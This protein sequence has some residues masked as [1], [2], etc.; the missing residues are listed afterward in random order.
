MTDFTLPELGENIAAGDV[1]RVLV[2]TGDTVAK[3][4]AILE[5][6]TDKATMEGPWSGA[7]V[8]KDV[9]VKAGQKTKVGQTIL[10]VD[11]AGAGAEAP[12]TPAKQ[13]EPVK[14]EPVKPEPDKPGPDPEPEDDQDDSS[15]AA[16]RQRRGEV[17]DI[18]RAARTAPQA[19]P[20]A[21]ANAMS[22]ASAPPAAP[23][24]RRIARELGVDIR[25]V[26]GTGPGGRITVD[27]VQGFVRLALSAV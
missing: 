24:V 18:S 21:E 8:V 7:G 19:A 3:D 27:D 14:A 1:V 6:E 25:Q 15:T 2:K 20:A 22:A 5:L 11:D 13:A 26:S 4:Q 16:P 10:S 17:V 9:Q 23:S 12:A